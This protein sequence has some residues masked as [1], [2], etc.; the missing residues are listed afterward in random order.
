MPPQQHD[1]DSQ[2][3][4]SAQYYLEHDLQLSL[5]RQ[6][7]LLQQAQNLTG[8]ILLLEQ[9]EELHLRQ[10]DVLTERVLQVENSAAHERNLVVE[11]QANCT[12]LLLQ[13]QSLEGNVE[14]WRWRCQELVNQTQQDAKELATL[15]KE[16]KAA[17]LEA[18]DLAALIEKHRLSDTEGDDVYASSKRKNRG[19]LAW[20]FGWGSEAREDKDLD[21]VYTSARSTLLAALQSERN[22]VHELEAAVNSLQQ[23]NTA[24][25]EQVKSR[26]L[27]IDEL[28]DRIAVFEEDKLVLKAALKQLQKDL[29]AEAPRTQ[30]LLD[31]LE[32]SK[33]EIARLKKEI[34]ALIDTHREEVAALRETISVKEDSIHQTES[35]LTVI[36]TYVDRLEARLA[37][38]AIARRDIEVRESKC[39]EIEKSA[40]ES[41]Q[42]REQLNARILELESEK[43]EV[44][45][46][47]QE[48]AS[49][50]ANLRS[51]NHD[52]T[53]EIRSLKD[54]ETRLKESLSSLNS[55][56]GELATANMELQ[57]KL[58]SYE[59]KQMDIAESSA[60]FRDLLNQ[61][62]A[63]LE[64]TQTQLQAALSERHRLMSQLQEAEGHARDILNRLARAEAE[65]ALLSQNYT[66]LQEKVRLMSH[67]SKLNTICLI[68]HFPLLGRPG[69]S[70]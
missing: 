11:Y 50:R 44:K 2:F 1:Q 3:Y 59:H 29:N 53:S 10:L 47:L 18:E 17:L 16:K 41:A 23:N 48:L 6:Q 68:S 30:K 5:Q 24:I 46:L 12:A 36:G 56:Y 66:L 45:A 49:E 58:D 67:D 38:F 21:G 7:E 14:Q 32:R 42:E 4:S 33:K 54:H 57:H 62:D 63:K 60:H 40:K 27:I 51:S 31:D 55:D 19:F 70:E 65:N 43:E 22:S 28:N 39:L 64:E 9:R 35:N 37:E 52:L 13:V 34:K 20:L 61:T 15:K 69:A 8:M 25:S 26:D